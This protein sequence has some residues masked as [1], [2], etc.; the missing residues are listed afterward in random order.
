MNQ[1]S[2]TSAKWKSGQGIKLL[3]L[4]LVG[5]IVTVAYVKYGDMLTLNSLA[6]R[7]AQLREYQTSNP[8]IVF[9]V[10]FL[11]YVGITGL[12][13]PGAAVLTLVFGWY[14]QFTRGVVLV[15][16]AS[17][18]GATVAFLLSRHLLGSTIQATFGDRLAAFNEAL[19][20]EGPYYLF[21]LRLIPAVPFFV[22]NV[23]MG[24]TQIKTSTYWWVSQLGML[25]GTI[26]YV[27]AGSQF[28]NLKDL[29]EKGT[30]EILSPQLFAAFIL[31]GLFPLAV[32]K[33][34]ASFASPPAA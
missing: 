16:L 3:I 34:M 31:L 27:Y 12:S 30:R 21:S 13:L 29:A 6:A 10:A 4:L 19:D 20:R 11:V 2:A 25:P 26:V 18:T 28:P 9:G 32:K 24:L 1:S 23:V 5:V 15:S 22:I 8:V 7:E 14:F 33:L 17:T